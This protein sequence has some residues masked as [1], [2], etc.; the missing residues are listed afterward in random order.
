MRLN[1]TV[2]LEGAMRGH[3]AMLGRTREGVARIATD[4]LVKIIK[5]GQPVDDEMQ[6]HLDDV[7]K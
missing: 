2:H 7:C 4:C 1:R 5:A 3:I 6:E